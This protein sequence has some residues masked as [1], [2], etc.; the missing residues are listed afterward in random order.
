MPPLE[1]NKII[2]YKKLYKYACSLG[3]YKSLE[4]HSAP[5]GSTHHY[6]RNYKMFSCCDLKDILN[7]ISSISIQMKL[8]KRVNNTVSIVCWLQVIK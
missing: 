4:M 1:I 6:L 8:V 3:L 2:I 7:T 5:Q